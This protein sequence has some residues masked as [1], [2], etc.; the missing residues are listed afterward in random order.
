TPTP[1]PT[2]SPVP[3]P[4]DGESQVNPGI[5]KP[6]IRRG[7]GI[8]DPQLRATVTYLQRL[9]LRGLFI[10]E[11]A[12]IDG[13][14]G[15]QTENG[16]KF[17]Q[18][19]QKLVA[20]GIVGSSTWLA[21]ESFILSL[22]ETA[23]QWSV[24][25][26]EDIPVSIPAVPSSRT[27]PILQRGD[28]ITAPNLRQDVKLLQLLLQRAGVLSANAAIDGEFGPGTD[29]AV[30]AFQEQRNLIVDG[31]AGGQTWMSLFQQWVG[32]YYPTRP[33]LAYSDRLIASLP[34]SG[35]RRYAASSIPLILQECQ[36]DSVVD[37]AQIA[38]ILA[39]A[40]HESRLGQWMLEF[41]SGTAYEGRA[42]LGNTQPGDGVRYK[43]RGFVQITGRLNYTRWSD[44]SGLDLLGNPVLTEEYNI[45]AIILV[46]G[47]RDGSF[48]GHKMDDYLSGDR[49]DFRNARRIVNGL[50]KADLIAGYARDFLKVMR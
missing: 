28:G 48:T 39:T 46:L 37:L 31:L 17:F 7:A 4:T 26:P 14:F 15:R 41:A 8:D 10:P 27:Y 42:D 24:A 19:R 33:L 32:T 36:R 25:E 16:V 44:R 20:D 1:T 22:E 2:P 45:A 13:Q 12:M 3:A 30:R 29:G 9:L 43:G 6:L 21:L 18:V 49:Q 5:P 35:M 40:R 47:M 50:D 38:Y 11:N 34:D 23:A